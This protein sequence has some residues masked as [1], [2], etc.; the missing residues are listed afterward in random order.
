MFVPIIDFGSLRPPTSN[1][2]IQPEACT[3]FVL[4]RP[5]FYKTGFSFGHG[6]KVDFHLPKNRKYMGIS[7]HRGSH[8]YVVMGISIYRAMIG[9]LR[10]GLKSAVERS[11]DAG[12]WR[13]GRTVRWRVFT[14]THSNFNTTQAKSDRVATD[15]KE[16]G[17]IRGF[18]KGSLK[19]CLILKGCTTL[20]CEELPDPIDTQQQPKESETFISMPGRAGY[21][22]AT[23]I[24]LILSRQNCAFQSTGG[25]WR[26][27]PFGV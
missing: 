25:K 17:A 7:P 4:R 1:P 9:K 10:T 12:K 3:Y 26:F 24:H 11:C 27:L 13:K 14:T 15:K 23:S 2:T 16:L 8:L 18:G 20:R 19:R 22:Q 6:I 5:R 21:E